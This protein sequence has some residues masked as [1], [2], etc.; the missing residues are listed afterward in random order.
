MSLANKKVLVT[1]ATGFIGCRLAERLALEEGAV[2]T[3][4]GRNLDKVPA[5]REAGVE[6]HNVDMTDP[7]ALRE[8][9]EGQ[10]IVFHLVAAMGGASADP[11]VAQALN[12]S[13]G[14]YLARG[15]A[16][17]GVKR[18]VHVSTMAVYG[19]PDHDLITE[20]HP[21][22]TEQYAPYGRTKALGELRVREVA[23][24][25]DLALTVV[26]PGLVFGPRGKSWTINLL[27]LVQ[28]RVPVIIGDGSGHAQIVYLDNLVDGMLMAATRPE[29]AGEAFNFVDRP[30]PWR[31]LFTYYGEMCGRKPLSLPWLWLARLI[32]PVFIRLT[33]RTESTADL[34]KFY[35]TKSVY[36]IDKA[37]DLL[38]YEPR[39]SVDEG[40][41]RSEAWL[42]EAGYLPAVAGRQAAV[43]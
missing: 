17:A 39:I 23:E 24:E 4:T 12:V 37:R 36:P 32:L 22:D 34:L 15:A 31:D 42:R 16:A 19:A 1:G 14:E 29:A 21:L 18:F 41:R 9:V 10:E 2:V 13:A 6:L 28:R 40:M 30:L 25:L 38:G 11:E 43:A 20:D 3:G 7:V 26:R 8:I 27:Q 5:L 33:G 35:T